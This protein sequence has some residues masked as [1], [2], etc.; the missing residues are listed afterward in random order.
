MVLGV[1]NSETE[2]KALAFSGLQKPRFSTGL[3]KDTFCPFDHLHGNVQ[4]YNVRI[5]VLPLRSD[6]GPIR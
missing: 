3:L 4:V 5:S 1:T 6:S 2:G